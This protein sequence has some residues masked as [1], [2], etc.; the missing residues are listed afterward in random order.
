MNSH[1]VS[2]FSCSKC[3]AAS[4]QMLTSHCCSCP[5]SLNL[6]V[7]DAPIGVSV[8]VTVGSWEWSTKVKTALEI[9]WT[10][11]WD[12]WTAS[13]SFVTNRR[14][15]YQRLQY[16]R[17]HKVCYSKNFI[18]LC[19]SGIDL[20]SSELIPTN[21]HNRL[22]NNVSKTRLVCGRCAA[23]QRS[24]VDGISWIY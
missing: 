24:L 5:V 10:L 4:V 9:L 6:N 22:T 19:F 1:R 20:H 23:V 3:D 7:D 8:S 18:L 2:L 21:L 13:Y 15:V 14:Q 17:I 16:S 11:F 12:S